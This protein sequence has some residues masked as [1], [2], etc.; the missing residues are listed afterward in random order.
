[1]SEWTI[2]SSLNLHVTRSFYYFFIIIDVKGAYCFARSVKS[3][4][5]NFIGI[6]SLWAYKVAS[7][8]EVIDQPHGGSLFFRKFLFFFRF[9]TLF[10]VIFPGFLFHTQFSGQVSPLVDTWEFLGRFSDWPREAESVIGRIFLSFFS[11][12][13][14]LT[15][16]GCDPVRRATPFPTFSPIPLAFSSFSFLSLVL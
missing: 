10:L 8:N 14:S 16:L 1:M 12:P 13:R 2:F 6:A 5:N 3:R 15:L 11:F 4:G 7:F 9:S